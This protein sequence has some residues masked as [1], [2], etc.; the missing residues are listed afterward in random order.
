MNIV[1]FVDPEAQLK[2]ED[3]NWS[4]YWDEE[5]QC[6]MMAEHIY[7]RSDPNNAWSMEDCEDCDATGRELVNIDWE[8]AISCEDYSSLGKQRWYL[9]KRYGTPKP[10]SIVD[11][12]LAS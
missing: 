7:H 6:W 12:W 4:T 1:D 11:Y 5:S 2:I 8:N 10:Q 9:I 3:P